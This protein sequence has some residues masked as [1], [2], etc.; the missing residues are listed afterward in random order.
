M[1]LQSLDINLDINLDLY[2]YIKLGGNKLI[3]NLDINLDIN[4]DKMNNF[5]N[6]NR[7]RKNI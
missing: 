2:L 3:Y 1:A 7:S 6:Q 5:F 4:L